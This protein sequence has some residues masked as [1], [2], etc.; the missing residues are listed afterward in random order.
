MGAKGVVEE[1]CGFTSA[2][3]GRGCVREGHGW[4][5]AWL[6]KAWLEK[7]VCLRQQE[8]GVVALEKDEVG[9]GRGCERRGWVMVNPNPNPT[10]ARQGRGC[11]RDGH[12][13]RRAWLRQN[14]CMSRP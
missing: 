6:Q 9:E 5:R 10:S 3:Q 8:K 13:W 14:W 7:R 11:V 12:G 4:R 2:R 1:G